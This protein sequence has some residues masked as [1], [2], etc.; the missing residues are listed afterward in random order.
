MDDASPEL[1]DIGLEITVTT[2][3]SAEKTEPMFDAWRER[4]PIYLALLRPRAVTLAM[5]VA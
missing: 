5:Q 4:C 2:P 3:D 1:M